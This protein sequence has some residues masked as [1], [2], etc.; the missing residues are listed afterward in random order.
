MSIRNRLTL[1]YALMLIL[2]LS[3]LTVI[4]VSILH[5]ALLGSVDRT[6]EQTVDEVMQNIS[7]PRPELSLPDFQPRLSFTLPNLDIF[8]ASDVFVQAWNNDGQY[9]GG[10][11]N[12]GDYRL[13]LDADALSTTE[14]TLRQ[15]TISGSTFRVLTRPFIINN[16]ILGRIQAAASLETIEDA[17]GGVAIVMIAAGIVAL[18]FSVFLSQAMLE[19]ALRPIEAMANTASQITTG[20]DLSRRISYD[21]PPDELGR[22]VRVFNDT[23]ARLEALFQAQRRFVAD[24]SHELRTPLTVIQGSADLIKRYGDKEALDAIDSESKRMSRLV[25]DLLLLA[26]A[27]AGGLPMSRQTLELDTLVLELLEQSHALA[28]NGPTVRLDRFEPVRVNADPDRLKQLFLNLIG[29]AIK[30][31]PTEGTITLSVWHNGLDALVSVTDSGEG[32]PEEDVPHIFERFYRV[33]KARARKQGGAGLGLSIAQW[34]A[35]AHGGWITVRSKL[36][37]GTTFTVHLPR[38]IPPPE[39]TADTVL[40][41]RIPRPARNPG[42]GGTKGS[43][44]SSGRGARQPVRAGDSLD[45]ALPP[46]PEESGAR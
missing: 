21:G 35:E 27:D 8:R 44:R 23:L 19:R 33:D 31:T 38:L 12:L 11:T 29:N 43:P 3:I 32:I 30:H 24:V 5:W 42:G 28:P 34:I 13:P 17:Q 6:L 10:S 1:T 4:V 41:M 39:T 46:P 45:T 40:N 14:Q 9:S 20:D 37:E 15:V 25:G 36:G 2:I 7:G 26:Q 18:I 16:R 22:L